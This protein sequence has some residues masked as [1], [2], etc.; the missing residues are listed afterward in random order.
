MNHH[1]RRVRE[2]EERREAI[3]DAA[4][5]VF[6]CK[7]FD[8]TPMDDIARQAQLSRALLYVYFEDKAAIMRGIMVR[9][10]RS[11]AVRFERALREGRTGM[12]QLRGFGR[13]YYAFSI[14]ESDY[15]DVLTNLNTFP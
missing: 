14:E 3:L 13:E 11:I 5:Q 10:A 1:A 9:A 4:E 12:E 2:K 7:G 15:F 8:R 6:F